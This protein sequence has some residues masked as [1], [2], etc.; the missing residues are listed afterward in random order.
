M[1][2]RV[3]LDRRVPGQGLAEPPAIVARLWRREDEAKPERVL[4]GDKLVV[5]ETTIR[6]NKNLANP[7]PNAPLLKRIVRYPYRQDNGRPRREQV[8]EP[9]VAREP[10]RSDSF[11]ELVATELRYPIA[12]GNPVRILGHA[13]ERRV[14]PTVDEWLAGRR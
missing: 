1:D 10:I 5:R 3:R 8:Y 7:R 11:E 4:A 2:P 12:L 6:N 9:T 14:L 13:I